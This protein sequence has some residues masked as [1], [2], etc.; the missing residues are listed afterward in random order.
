VTGVSTG[1]S[2]ESDAADLARQLAEWATDEL[3]DAKEMIRRLDEI[4]LEHHSSPVAKAKAITLAADEFRF[5][6]AM[7][8]ARWAVLACRETADLTPAD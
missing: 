1:V 6:D 4:L 5:A 2:E 7:R 8:S 3:M